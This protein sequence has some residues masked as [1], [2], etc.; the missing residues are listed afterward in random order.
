MNKQM[1]YI[2]MVEYYSALPTV[3]WRNLKNTVLS[4]RNQTQMTTDCMV[5]FI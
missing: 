4:E 5:P 2:R 1:C 3:T